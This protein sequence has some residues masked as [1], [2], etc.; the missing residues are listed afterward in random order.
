MPCLSTARHCLAPPLPA[1]GAG[2]S[3]TLNAPMC[4][5]PLPIDKEFGHGQTH[6]LAN[7]L[8][9]VLL[10]G[11]Q[12][13]HHRFEVHL[14]RRMQQTC[15]AADQDHAAARTQCN[16]KECSTGSV[17]SASNEYNESQQRRV[18]L[19]SLAADA[20]RRWRGPC[21]VGRVAL[22]LEAYRA[23]GAAPRSS[24]SGP[25][26]CLPTMRACRTDLPH[27]TPWV[28]GSQDVTRRLRRNA[29]LCD[30]IAMRR[31][32][33]GHAMPG[34]HRNTHLSGDHQWGGGAA[35]TRAARSGGTAGGAGR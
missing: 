11:L 10:V 27:G 25:A 18:W 9:F 8:T 30:A 28:V 26:R 12:D 22:V 19:T 13:V 5:K 15:R 6:A 2:R 20:S 24:C 3:P 35:T 14:L 29:L 23:R 7:D 34:A 1:E 17:S 16:Q 32:L 31:L 33:C 4:F 21:R